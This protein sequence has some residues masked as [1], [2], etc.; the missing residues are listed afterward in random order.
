LVKAQQWL[1]PPLTMAY[2]AAQRLVSI[3]NG[4]G[5][6]NYTY[7]NAGNMTV[8]ANESNIGTTT[9]SYDPENRLIGIQYSNGTLSTYTYQG[10]GLRRSAIEPGGSLT[11]TV[12]DGTDYLQE[13]S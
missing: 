2:D 12:W 13:R 3:A 5:I 7:D 9:Y 10:D 11:T 6:V 4:A 1:N 8:E